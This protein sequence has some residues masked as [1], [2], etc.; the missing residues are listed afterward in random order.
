MTELDS[1][2]GNFQTNSQVSVKGLP[3]K[4]SLQPWAAMRAGLHF[5]PASIEPGTSATLHM[6]VPLGCPDLKRLLPTCQAS[7]F[8]NNVLPVEAKVSL[9][10]ICIDSR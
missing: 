9:R 5:S 7:F 10:R 6:T 1:E 3:R 8:P 4:C 2:M